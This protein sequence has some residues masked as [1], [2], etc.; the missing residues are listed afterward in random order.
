MVL[1]NELAGAELAVGPQ[2]GPGSTEEGG[3]EAQ[4]C[5]CHGGSGEA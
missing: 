2:P 4:P 3:E 5:V 1:G